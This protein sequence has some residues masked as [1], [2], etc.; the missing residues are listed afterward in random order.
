LVASGKQPESALRNWESNDY[1]ALVQKLKDIE[2]E[3]HD[4][5]E[6]VSFLTTTCGNR[7]A[8]RGGRGIS[9]R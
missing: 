5:I 9:V 6:P 2:Q 1:A 4:L 8:N 3:A 7:A